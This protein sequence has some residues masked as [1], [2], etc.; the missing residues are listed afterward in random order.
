M[1]TLILAV[2]MGTSARQMESAPL[3]FGLIQMQPLK[4]AVQAKASL[5]AQGKCPQSSIDHNTR[6]HG[7]ISRDTGTD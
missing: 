5:T 1:N 6:F 2:I 4:A 7:S 3:L